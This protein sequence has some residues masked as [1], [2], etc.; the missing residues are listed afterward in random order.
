MLLH[1]PFYLYEYYEYDCHLRVATI[2]A[3]YPWQLIRMLAKSME[4][5][6]QPLTLPLKKRSKRSHYHQLGL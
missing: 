1:G 3:W 2:Y 4:M 6:I 5:V